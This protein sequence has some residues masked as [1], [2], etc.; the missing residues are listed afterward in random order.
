[1][2][3]TRPGL[4]RTSETFNRQRNSASSYDHALIRGHTLLFYSVRVL[5]PTKFSAS[6]RVNNVIL[7]HTCSFSSEWAPIRLRYRSF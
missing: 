2:L 3:E 7:H 6:L 1:M 4:I 5:S